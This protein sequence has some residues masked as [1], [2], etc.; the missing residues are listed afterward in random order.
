MLHRNSAAHFRNRVCLTNHSRVVIARLPTCGYAK[1][2]DGG[3]EGGAGCEYDRYDSEEGTHIGDCAFWREKE[4]FIPAS[5]PKVRAGLAFHA[6]R[7]RQFAV[8]RAGATTSLAWFRSN[9]SSWRSSCVAGIRSC[10]RSSAST[11]DRS[12]PGVR[13][14]LRFGSGPPVLASSKLTVLPHAVRASSATA[15]QHCR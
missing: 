8:D 9:V 5:A 11:I 1:I 15:R 6:G 4:K 2:T 3:G 7:L 10:R 13:L 14:L 12:R